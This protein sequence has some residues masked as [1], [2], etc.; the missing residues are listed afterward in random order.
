MRLL[1]L[2]LVLTACAVLVVGELYVT[3]PLT[4]Q[5]A[6]RF[7]VAPATAAL[8][9]S[10]FGLAYAVGFLVLGPLA[11][12]YDRARFLVAGL[13]AIAAATALVP[14]VQSFGVLLGARA[15]QGL[16]AATFPP[17]A[18]ALV[19]EVLPPRWRATGVSMLS[20]AFL[21]SAPLVQIFAAR[22][23]DLATVATVIAVGYLVGAAGV[24]LLAG[25]CAAAAAPASPAGGRLAALMRDPGLVAAW[26]ASLTVLFA[27]V[28]FHAGAQLLDL[29]V[30]RE[31]LRL[32]GLPPL[33]LTL[34]AA[35]LSARVG[36]PVTA[37]LG[38]VLEAIAFVPAVAGGPA[39]TMLASVLVAAGVA[40]AVPGLISTVAMR[41][42][43]SDRGL[44]I[45]IYGFVLFV[46][47]SLAPPV[48]AGLAGAGAVIWVVP[49]VGL[50]ASAVLMAAVFRRAPRIE[51]GRP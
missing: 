14:F 38:I 22:V 43:P 47:A 1:S 32:V 30:D 36:A 50:V 7:G 31:T 44:A 3:I 2:V 39:A 35:P 18:L 5:I 37:M 40:L 17:A 6:D 34:V 11:D 20:F 12:R 42:T 10:A 19:V 4:A 9:G 13:G 28:G 23:G 24:L 25:R 45:A 8:A 16:A 48:A 51:P 49:A 21:G 46:G 41:S 33:L 29:G 26:A 15:L 27:F